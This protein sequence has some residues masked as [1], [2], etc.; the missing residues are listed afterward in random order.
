MTEQNT[1]EKSSFKIPSPLMGE[2]KGEGENLDAHRPNYCN[3]SQEC[4]APSFDDEKNCRYFTPSM[5]FY[6]SGGCI[7]R[8][9]FFG[10]LNPAAMVAAKEQALLARTAISAA[11]TNPSPSMGEGMGE[12][13]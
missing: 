9:W 4:T 3:A 2:G 1:M 5:F 8:T 10:C 7:L 13:E 12:G 11:T 6:A